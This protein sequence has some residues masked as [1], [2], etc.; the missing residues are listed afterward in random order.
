MGGHSLVQ[1]IFL[2][3][4]SNLDL[5]YCRQILYRLSHQALLISASGPGLRGCSITADTRKAVTNLHET[6]RICGVAAPRPRSSKGTTQVAGFISSAL[7]SGTFPFPA[8]SSPIS[9]TAIACISWQ[10]GCCHHPK[11][12]ALFYPLLAPLCPSS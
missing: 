7:L 5:L 2:T 12:L 3:Q 11:T 4:G 6:K 1:A 9:L 8:I 10:A